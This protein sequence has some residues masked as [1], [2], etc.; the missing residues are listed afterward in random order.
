MENEKWMKM[1]DTI[2]SYLHWN[3]YLN[4]TRYEMN[5]YIFNKMNLQELCDDELVITHYK[6][7]DRHRDFWK[8]LTKIDKYEDFRKYVTERLM[9]SAYREICEH[10][11]DKTVN[12]KRMKL[13]EPDFYYNYYLPERQSGQSEVSTPIKT[14]VKSGINKFSISSK[15]VTQQ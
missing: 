10:K 15:H 2:Y 12:E 3:G 4:N 13:E 1:L 5:K 14:S 7:I 9:I 11:F 8:G 6:D